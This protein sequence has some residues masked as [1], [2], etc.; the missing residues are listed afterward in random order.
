[1]FGFYVYTHQVP[2]GPYGNWMSPECGYVKG[3]CKDVEKQEVCL[4]GLLFK[5]D[6]SWKWHSSWS[7]IA[8]G[9]KRLPCYL[10]ILGY[11]VKTISALHVQ[12][13]HTSCDIGFSSLGAQ[14][15]TTHHVLPWDLVSVVISFKGNAK[16][17]L[18]ETRNSRLLLFSDHTWVILE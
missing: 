8:E 5:E 13:Y 1:M 17:S 6:H 12:L 7:T 11:I 14:S 9:H 3:L 18:P 4:L 15:P 10:E 2:W 16:A